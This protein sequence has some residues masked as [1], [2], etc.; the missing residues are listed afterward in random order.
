MRAFEWETHVGRQLEHSVSD[1][2]YG[3]LRNPPVI[4]VV[5]D[6]HSQSLHRE[7]MPLVFSP[8]SDPYFL[9]IKI[10]PHK[11]P[12]ALA[13]IKARWHTLEPTLPFDFF[14]LDEHIDRQYRDEERWGRIIGYASFF[15]ILIAS[16]G[17][18]GLVALSVSRRVKEIG[19]RKVLGASASSIVLL[20]SREFVKLVI[21]A[22]VVAWPVAYLVMRDWLQDFAY[23]IDLDIWTFA[24]GGVLTLALALLS[25]CSQAIKAASANPVDALRYE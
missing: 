22:N 11:I 12:E 14:F 21:V 5:K 17:A 19:I 23:R 10:H 8:A 7:I 1:P 24:A 4:G 18:F 15:A 3:K 16:L 6:F 13:R 20:F 2:R 9:Y 25:V